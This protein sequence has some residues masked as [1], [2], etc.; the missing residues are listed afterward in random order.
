MCRSSFQIAVHIQE[1]YQNVRRFLSCVHS[2]EHQNYDK[3][4]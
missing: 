4:T 3:K 1:N 2:S